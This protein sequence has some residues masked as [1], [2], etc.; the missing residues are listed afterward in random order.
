MRKENLTEENLQDISGGT[1]AE[2]GEIREFIK[3]NDPDYENTP[4]DEIIVADWLDE[5]YGLQQISVKPYGMNLYDF[6]GGRTMN[7]AELMDFLRSNYKG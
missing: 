6:E 5:H 1:F 7:H 2:L 4:V 3:A